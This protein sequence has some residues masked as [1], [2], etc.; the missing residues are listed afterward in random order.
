[1]ETTKRIVPVRIHVER[2]LEQIK[3]F[4]I[5]QGVMPLAGSDFADHIFFVSTAVINLLSFR[6][7][8]NINSVEKL[9]FLIRYYRS[10]FDLSI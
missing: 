1:M 6:V 8:V 3:K 4:R 10:N 5:L 7:T 9:M 2:K